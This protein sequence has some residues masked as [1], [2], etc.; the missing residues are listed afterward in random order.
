MLHDVRA[1]LDGHLSFVPPRPA[2]RKAIN[3]VHK[4]WPKLTAYVEVGRLRMD[5]KLT[6]NTIRPF[7]IGHRN[8]LSCDT[9][10]GANT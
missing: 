7:V 4:Q 8:W 9:I 6:Q 5:S 3:Y 2:L 10:G 1:W